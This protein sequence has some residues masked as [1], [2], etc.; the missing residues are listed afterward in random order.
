MTLDPNPKVPP[1]AAPAGTALPEG[2]AAALLLE[3]VALVTLK[4]PSIT[5]DEREIL[6]KAVRVAR[7][8]QKRFPHPEPGAQE[9]GK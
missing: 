1:A 7:S 5:L 8:I 9:P 3:Q 6:E 4:D 2:I